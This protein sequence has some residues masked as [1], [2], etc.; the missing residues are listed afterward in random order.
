MTILLMFMLIQEIEVKKKKKKKT[1]DFTEEVI[2]KDY[3]SPLLYD[4]VQSDSASNDDKEIAK[5]F[6]EMLKNIEPHL[7]KIIRW[8]AG[9]YEAINEPVVIECSIPAALSLNEFRISYMEYDYFQD[10]SKSRY[11]AV[12]WRKRS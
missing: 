3:I 4:I 6:L 5:Q 2:E 7:P 9:C 12:T 8:C 1:H 11:L 10:G